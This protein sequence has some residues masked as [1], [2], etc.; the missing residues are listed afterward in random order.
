MTPRITYGPWGE[1][2]A[3][4]AEATRAAERAGATIAWFPELHRSATVTAAAAAAAT[5]EIGIGTAIALAFV[6]S[7]LI[8][9]LEAL[10]IDELS[11]G[12]FRLGL[13]SG[14]QRVIED[15]HNAQWGK[16][17]AHLR[18]TI[19]VV[20]HVVANARSGA[21]LLVEGEWERLRMRGFQRPFP[22][23]RTELPIYIAGVGPAMTALAGEAGDGFISHELCSPRYLTERVLPRLRQGA[24]RS[25]RPLQTLD[26]TVS[27]CCSIDDDS[28]SARRRAAGLVG[29]YA[30]VRTYADFFAFHGL[31][32][33]H[34]RVSEAFR[35][36]TPADRLGSL[37][38]DE[39][40]DRLTISGTPDEVRARL[41][42]YEGLAD[43]VKLT[44]P[45]H[46]L[47]A[48]EIRIAQSRIFDLIFDLTGVPRHDRH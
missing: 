34:S 10:D 35:G 41:A 42:A 8:T 31:A 38:S 22:Q 28:V 26:V 30:S 25:G 29:F 36:G 6:R 46:G 1:T 20:R 4:L 33:D 18:E 11:G 48:E 9:A 32:E 40:V 27:A 5:S 16:P 15:W 12:R 2:L 3:E 39:A 43:S 7:P 37:V 24:Q 13:G 23:T 21:D 44:P 14:V 45:T 17:V 47:A 19:A